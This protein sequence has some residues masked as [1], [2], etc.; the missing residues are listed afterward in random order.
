LPG[1]VQRCLICMRL[2]KGQL[3]INANQAYTLPIAILRYASI[4]FTVSLASL[5]S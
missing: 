3:G 5:T 1:N 4:N 2:Q